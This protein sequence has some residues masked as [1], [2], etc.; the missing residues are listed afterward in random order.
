MKMTHIHT[1]VT[2]IVVVLQNRG[3]LSIRYRISFP[4]M[5]VPTPIVIN[6][7]DLEIMFP[8][9]KG[10]RTSQEDISVGQG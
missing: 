3:S 4:K 7:R 1:H 6:V 5:D 10:R 9:M 2:S 8:R